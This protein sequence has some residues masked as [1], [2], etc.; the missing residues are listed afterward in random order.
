MPN[1][2]Y[3]NTLLGLAAGYKNGGRAESLQ[4]VMDAIS[5]LQQSPMVENMLTKMLQK[6]VD[7]KVQTEN[8]ELFNYLKRLEKVKSGNLSVL[9]G[10]SGQSQVDWDDNLQKTM[11][12]YPGSKLRPATEDELSYHKGILNKQLKELG[13]L[14]F[15][16]REG[17]IKSDVILEDVQKFYPGMQAFEGEERVFMPREPIDPIGKMLWDKTYQH[18]RGHQGRDLAGEKLSTK[19]ELWSDRPEERQANRDALNVLKEN[20]TRAGL[21]FNK[22]DAYRWITGGSKVEA[23]E[24]PSMAPF[25]NRMKYLPTGSEDTPYE[26]SLLQSDWRNVGEPSVKTTYDSPGDYMDALNNLRL[27]TLFTQAMTDPSK[28]FRD[29]GVSTRQNIKSYKT[30]WDLINE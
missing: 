30:F 22:I 26:P 11:S 13:V 23:M 17:G 9:E 16:E 20:F 4:P 7:E 19:E 24:N 5:R 8:A 28:A 21:P 27:R 25:I 3:R 14:D 12:R 6:T 2:P 10:K 1:K 29:A 18:E 15:R